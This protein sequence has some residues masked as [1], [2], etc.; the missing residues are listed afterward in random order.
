[1]N[2]LLNYSSF[3]NIE[4]TFEDLLEKDYS[5]L[6]EL[7]KNALEKHLELGIPT[8]KDE[9]W[10]YTSLRSF[11]EK[12]FYPC[13]LSNYEIEA[14]KYLING[15]PGAQII[16]ENGYFI[17]EKSKNLEVSGIKIL[18][19]QE[20]FTDH[21]DL[22]KNYLGN[23]NRK[24]DFTFASLNTALFQ[25]IVFIYVSK[26]T[27][28]KT[29][30]QISHISNPKGQENSSYVRILMI[31]EEG[32]EVQLIENYISHTEEISF[33][34][35]VVEIKI[36]QNAKVE[37]I[38][39]QNENLKSYHIALN[40]ID[41]ERDSNYT[42]VNMTFGGQLTR[43]D[44]NAW[45]GGTGINT[46]LD[47]AN[48]LKKNQLS[49]THTC[50]DH[51][52]PNCYS[53]EM[54]KGILDDQSVGVFNGKIFVHEDAQKTDA[55]QTNQ[56]IL[57][58]KQATINTKPQ[59]E[60]FADDVKCTHGATIGQLSNESIFYLKAR[61]ISEEQAKAMLVHAFAG[62]VIQTV[63]IESVK[64]HLEALLYAKLIN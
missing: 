15:L 51:A 18:N 17:K 14:K 34:N 54:Y 10:R 64:D 46:T 39:I 7:R 57:L 1:M 11:Q 55:K 44:T 35:S 28:S 61:G 5:W 53:W 16:L 45:L 25:D 8:L 13:R 43:N 52:F 9:E 56:A 37:H 38:K 22:L 36:A 4:K 59:L 3:L 33:T 30:I 40:Q 26:N 19:L 60:I 23:I 49:D 21:N 42:T 6:K 29:P 20:A 32:A 41:Q 12:V 2:G 58:S 31:V 24:N 62:E 63:S 48:I 47:G 27:I 50:I